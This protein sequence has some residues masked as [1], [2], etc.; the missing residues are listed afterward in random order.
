M[1]GISARGP[2]VGQTAGGVPRAGVRQPYPIASVRLLL[3]HRFRVLASRA[4]CSPLVCS[5][6]QRG[7]RFVS[8]TERATSECFRPRWPTVSVDAH[9]LL[10]PFLP[11]SKRVAWVTAARRR[12]GCLSMAESAR[13]RCASCPPPVPPRLLHVCVPRRRPGAVVRAP[14]VLYRCETPCC[15]PGC[16]RLTRRGM[17]RRVVTSTIWCEHA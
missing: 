13:P 5:C 8:T 12:S 1:L 4:W 15:I 3:P 7:L 2:W 10:S 9:A 16:V 6:R 11:K 14:L 17:R